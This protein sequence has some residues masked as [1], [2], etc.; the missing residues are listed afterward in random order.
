LDIVLSGDPAI[1]LLGIYQ[2]DAPTYNK[3]TCSTMLI[4]A[5]F[6]IATSWK[7]FRCPSTEEWIQ[8]IWYIYTIENNV[9]LKFSG[10]WMELENIILSGVTQSQRIKQGNS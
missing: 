2:G 9:F 3:N 10:K 4:E 6:I 1:L 5:L 7:E 8:K